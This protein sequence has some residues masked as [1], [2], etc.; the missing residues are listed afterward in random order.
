M[1]WLGLGRWIQA[2][3][4]LVAFVARADFNVRGLSQ[5]QRGAGIWGGDLL[6]FEHTIH[7]RVLSF[8]PQ[9]FHLMSTKVN[10]E[11]E[12][13]SE[14]EREIL[15]RDQK[16]REDDSSVGISYE[17]RR[18]RLYPGGADKAR[19]QRDDTRPESDI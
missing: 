6:C 3:A 1:L 15:K 9:G 12:L 14:N 7:P 19:R 18:Q 2:E 4:G 5:F 8:I 17:G 11:L 13:G 10:R 16:W